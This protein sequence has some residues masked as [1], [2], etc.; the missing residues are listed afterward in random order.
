MHSSH[1]EGRRCGGRARRF[2]HA[3]EAVF[4]SGFGHGR[5]GGRGGEGPFGEGTFGGG[6]F[7]GGRFGRHGG[8]RR[9]I[10]AETLRLAV[11]KLIAAEPRHGYDIIR[12]IGDLT[13]GAYAPSPGVVYPLLSLLA[14][15]GL[16]A[17]AEGDST[18]RSFALTADG[19]AYLDANADAA[20]AALQGLKALGEAAGG[21]DPAP[22]RR[23]MAN[24][25]AVLQASLREP[26]A[27]KTRLLE[28][29][30]L[31]DETA[32]KIERL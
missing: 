16:I 22:V 6:A 4:A 32:Q 26:G 2:G 15:M 30:A 31:I 21:V 9:R 1:H 19:E 13:G 17:Q 25:A 8:R 28:V 7:G 3:A 18:R 24:L 12:A 23:A 5:F 20:E 10:D 29:A 11:L 27:D 14:E